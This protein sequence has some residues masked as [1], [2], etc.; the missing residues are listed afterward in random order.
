MKFNIGP[1]RS[2]TLG[3]L[4]VTGA[5]AVTAVLGGC[6]SVTS[7]PAAAAH[8]A[9]QPSCSLSPSPPSGF[10]EQKVQVGGIGINYVRAYSYA[11]AHPD[12][13]TKLVLSEAPIPDQSIY[14]L[15]SGN[16]P[17]SATNS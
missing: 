2:T 14:G 10:T 5:V 12:D 16:L 15:P 13:V 9:A 6:S 4:A 3:S 7:G 11:A 1:L 17:C 8:E